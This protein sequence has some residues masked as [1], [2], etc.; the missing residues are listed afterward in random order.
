MTE[1]DQSPHLQEEPQ[2]ERGAPGSRDEGGPP[3]AGP[4]DRPAGTSDE[5]SDTGVESQGTVDP[6]MPDLP[7]G[8]QGG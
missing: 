1:R 5:R 6:D 3:G 8:D 2:E 7:A 4:S